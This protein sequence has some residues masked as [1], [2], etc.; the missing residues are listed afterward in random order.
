MFCSRCG[1]QVSDDAMF[2]PQ[3]G[4]TTHGGQV[5]V[6]PARQMPGVAC[7]HA[8]CQEPVIGQCS[9]YGRGCGRF[10]CAKHSIESFCSTC[11]EKAAH[12]AAIRAM[13]DD[14][15]AAAE[16]IPHGGCSNSGATIGLLGILAAGVAAAFVLAVS[17][18]SEW[19]IFMALVLVWAGGAAYVNQREAT[20]I[21]KTTTEKPG[22]ADFYEEY[23]KQKGREN[24][25][26]ALTA[27]LAVGAAANGVQQYRTR[28]D[29]HAIAKSLKNA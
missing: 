3:C 27:L 21:A 14:Y 16:K 6:A 24:M 25:A 12:D 19:L 13:Y 5:E 23:R 28:Q 7:H 29:I 26:N 8:G 9:G 22:F 15:L 2:C 4:A 11:A 10:F 17:P 20:A 1:T 18:G